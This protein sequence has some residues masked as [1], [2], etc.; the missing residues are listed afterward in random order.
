MKHT[1]KEAYI[2]KIRSGTIDIDHA[3]IYHTLRN[4]YPKQLTYTQIASK[5]KWPNQNKVSRRLKEMTELG[6][7]E[8]VGVI[9][10][11]LALRKCTVY[12][13]KL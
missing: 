2:E 10:C 8:D 5:L 1:S 7:I 3:W 6:L 12:K 9:V 11:P 4:E 13:A